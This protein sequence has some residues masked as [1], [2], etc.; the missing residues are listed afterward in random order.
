MFRLGVA[1]APK[2]TGTG[3]LVPAAPG[4]ARLSRMKASVLLCSLA[5]SLAVGWIL[6]PSVSMAQV[7]RYSAVMLACARL[8]EEV[9]TDLQ[10]SAGP[11]GHRERI[12]RSGTL[13]VRGAPAPAGVAV[14]LWYDSLTLWRERGGLR[15]EAETGGLVGGRYLGTLGLSGGYLAA[16]RP[17]LPDEVRE[18]ADL[19]DA[20]AEL[21]PPLA[22]LALG[23][24]GVVLLDGG[25]TLTRLRDSLSGG[26]AIGRYKLVGRRS[27]QETGASGDSLSPSQRVDEEEE[28]EVVWSPGRGLLAWRRTIEARAEAAAVVPLRGPIRTRLTE[29]ILVRRLTDDPDCAPTR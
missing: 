9:R 12:A 8:S 4:Q 25:W 24:G 18:M 14:T 3:R 5:A 22:D 17:F 23:P 26:T 6:S 15:E 13:Q 19:S 20:P 10:V 29:Q 1:L 28:G 27:R 7:P 16:D 21:F 11:A 2:L